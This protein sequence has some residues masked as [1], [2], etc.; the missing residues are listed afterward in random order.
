MSSYIQHSG[1]ETR[2]YPTFAS[3]APH[4]P[5]T[6]SSPLRASSGPSTS[7]VP[8]TLETFRQSHRKPFHT[9]W[10]ESSALSPPVPSCSV[11]AGGEQLYQQ[12]QSASPCCEPGPAARLRVAVTL[13][14]PSLSPLDARA[15]VHREAEA[16]ASVTRDR[17]SPQA[18]R[19]L[20]SEEEIAL[21]EAR[22]GST[23]SQECA[24][25]EAGPSSDTS[26]WGD[27]GACSQRAATEAAWG[28]VEV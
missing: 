9:T 6:P 10:P 11:P 27:K 23:G 5:P 4:S 16:L 3:S 13:A 18:G 14:G 24:R 8:D 25:P 15:R 7:W 28:Q 12:R 2:S 19:V 1:P 20:S 22:S 26:R 17:M 21:G